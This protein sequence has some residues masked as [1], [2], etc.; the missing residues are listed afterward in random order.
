MELETLE[1]KYT[2]TCFILPLFML[3]NPFSPKKYNFLC[4]CVRNFTEHFHC[5]NSV[6]QLVVVYKGFLFTT[7]SWLAAV[8]LWTLVVS[9]SLKGSWKKL[10]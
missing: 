4:A 1:S 8:T 7:V 10:Q 5:H 2:C 3:K 6:W 9:L